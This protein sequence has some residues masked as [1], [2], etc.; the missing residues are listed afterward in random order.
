[1]KIATEKD[2]WLEFR[3]VFECI[4]PNDDDTHSSIKELIPT[5]DNFL[6][7]SL[8]PSILFIIDYNTMQYLYFNENAINFT[9]GVAEDY[10]KG[11]IEFAVSNIHP[12][13]MSVLACQVF[14]YIKNFLK[15]IPPATYKDYKFAFN[16][17]YKRKDGAYQNFIQY[18]TYMP[19][20]AG[21]PRYNFGMGSNIASYSD[22]KLTLTIEKKETGGYKTVSIDT[23]TANSDTI[24]TKREC[25]VLKLLHK[26]LSS[27][28][29]AKQLS[30][31]EH[32]V[33]N[34][35]KNMLKK[36]ATSNTAALISYAIANG[37]I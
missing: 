35:R 19:D 14:P 25:E 23:I 6:N 5:L 21:N 8:A 29:I 11:G 24:F 34:H 36:T 16:F 32:T 3:K 7:L 33:N 30:L 1:M 28:A 26:G 10:L 12:D 31:S 2:Y 4:S 13:D 15:K 17:R 22:N 20:K 18:S 37:Y 27:A 9:G